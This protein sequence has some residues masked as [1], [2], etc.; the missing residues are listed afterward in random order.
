[1]LARSTL[2]RMSPTRYVFMSAIAGERNGDCLSRELTQAIGR[3]RRAVGEGFVVD[4]GQRVE[5]TEVLGID[6]LD[7]M[8]GPIAVGN[9][10]RIGCLVE[11]GVAKGDRAR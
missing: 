7:A 1:M 4:V 9:S 2:V 11:R 3:N 8:V 5:K 6:L 10:L